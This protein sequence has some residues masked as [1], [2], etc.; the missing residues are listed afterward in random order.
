[1]FVGRRFSEEILLGLAYAFEQATQISRFRKP[2]IQ[3]TADVLP[4]ITSNVSNIQSFFG[5][6]K[7]HLH[8]EDDF[9]A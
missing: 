9:G 4:T 5:Q 8:E 1:M 7:G 6:V 2:C 3:P